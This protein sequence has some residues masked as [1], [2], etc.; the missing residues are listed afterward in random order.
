MEDPISTEVF[1]KAAKVIVARDVSNREREEANALLA[2]LYVTKEAWNIAKEVLEYQTLEPGVLL[3]T[4]KIMRVKLFYYFSDLTEEL[5]IPLFQFLASSL[6]LTRPHDYDRR[7]KRA[8][9]HS[10]VHRLHLP[11][12]LLGKIDSLKKEPNLL[13]FLNR[14]YGGMATENKDCLLEI[15]EVIPGVMQEEK[16]VVE[17]EVRNQ[18]KS[19]MITHLQQPVLNIV[20]VCAQEQDIGVKRT[21]QIIRCF[22]SWLILDTPD[23]TKASLHKNHAID[24]CFKELAIVDGCNAEASD[25]LMSLLLVCKDYHK[26]QEIY[27]KILERLIASKE[28]LFNLFTANMVEEVRCYIDIYNTFVVNAFSEFLAN[29]Q[30]SIIK[31]LLEDIFLKLYKSRHLVTVS[32]INGVFISILR[33]MEDE[34]GQIVTLDT[35]ELRR[36]FVAVHQGFFEE[37]IRVACSHCSLSQV[38]MQFYEHNDFNQ[39]MDDMDFEDRMIVRA[40]TKTLLRKLVKHFTFDN[41]FRP[42]AGKLVATFEALREN[43]TEKLVCELEGEFFCA[44]ALLKFGNNAD[45]SCIKTVQDLLKIVVDNQSP[46][47]SLICISLKIIAASSA[48]LKDK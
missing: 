38:Q 22:E 40:D 48:Y 21:F 18:F 42:I 8:D 20:S 15:L 27:S 12:A 45:Q 35:T 43:K 31:L 34:E 7:E 28:Q 14:I 2:K 6:T 37:V 39:E 32:R 41:C 16:I 1:L 36:R 5:Y 47:H 13:D 9:T 33:Q 25:A 3:T 44:Y 29:P 19:F 23:E 11:Q 4:V 46:I 26:H 30:H 10:R 17:D 24:L